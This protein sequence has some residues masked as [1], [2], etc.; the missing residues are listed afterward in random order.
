MR[1]MIKANPKN[2]QVLQL[3]KQWDKRIAAVI[4]AMPQMVAERFLNEVKGRAPTSIKGYPDMLEIK[5]IQGFGDWEIAGVIPPGWVF[6]QRLQSIDVSRTVLYV[7]PRSVG[8]EVVSEA[9]V[10]LSRHNPWTMDTIPYEPNRR[11]A[12]IL[13]RRVTDRE[14]QPIESQRRRDLESIK[15][16]LRSLGVQM[17]PKGKVLLSRRVSRD[18]AFEILRHEFGVPPIVGR[19]HWR[20]SIHLLPKMSEKVFKEL[21]EWFANPGESRYTGVRDLQVEKAS[22]VK[23]VQKFQDFVAPA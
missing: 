4:K 19:A 6:S 1:F 10:V 13:S 22:V 7:R 2:K 17:R 14:V 11:E 16:E 3:L 8:G 12:S 5:T 9:A 21:S 18:I 15:T 23:R 20:P